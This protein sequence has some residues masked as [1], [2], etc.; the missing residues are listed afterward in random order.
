M[1]NTTYMLTDGQKQELSSM[2]GKGVNFSE[3]ERTFYAHD[4]G[5]LPSLV[6]TMLGK[7]KPAA[8]VKVLNEEDAVRLVNLARKHSIPVVPRARASSGYWRHHSHKRRNN[9]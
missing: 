8:I 9:S 7:T 6:K 2:F 4:V 3:K 1:A 5:A